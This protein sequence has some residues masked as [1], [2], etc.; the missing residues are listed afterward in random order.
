MDLIKLR[1]IIEKYN[2]KTRI[3]GDVDCNMMVLELHEPESFK[4]LH[5][6]YTSKRAGAKL[7]KE[8]F[9]YASIATFLKRNPEYEKIPRQ[10]ARAGDIGVVREKQC[11]YLHLGNSILIIA[12]VYSE[13]DPENSVFK[14]LDLSYIDPSSHEFY[15]KIKCPQQ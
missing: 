13:T 2:N 12:D 1:S 6:K 3:C 7:A 4:L 8:I 5:K 10:F 14:I 11:T 9:G 15:R